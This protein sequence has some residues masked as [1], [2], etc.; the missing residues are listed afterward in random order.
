MKPASKFRK[1]LTC[2]IRIRHLSEIMIFKKLKQKKKF[3]SE[4]TREYI[5]KKAM[6]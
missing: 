5:L 4:L 6:V 3:F 2:V 1:F